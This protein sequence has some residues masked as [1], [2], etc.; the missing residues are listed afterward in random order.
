MLQSAYGECGLKGGEQYQ[1]ALMSS[2]PRDTFWLRVLRR[3]FEQGQRLKD[4]Y[5]LTKLNVV[6]EIYK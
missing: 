3:V 1:N 5:L 6:S 4:L 2:V